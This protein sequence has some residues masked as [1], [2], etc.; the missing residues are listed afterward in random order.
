M[1]KKIL[2]LEQVLIVLPLR[3]KKEF[4]V[5]QFSCSTHP[6]NIYINYFEF[7][8]IGFIIIFALFIFINLIFL[9][10]LYLKIFKKKLNLQISKFVC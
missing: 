9:K 6:H 7:E 4:L 5:D 1:F 8:F 10:H 2:F 3:K